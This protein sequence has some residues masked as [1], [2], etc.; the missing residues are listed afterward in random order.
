[1]ASELEDLQSRYM[2][3]ARTL[4]DLS[5]I[6]AKQAIKIERLE[7]ALKSLQQQFASLDPALT[8]GVEIG[9]EQPPHY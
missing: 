9:T 6:A 4:E 1:M 5:D 8:G 7:R 2:D 3:L